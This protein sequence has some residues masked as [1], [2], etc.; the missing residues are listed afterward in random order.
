MFFHYRFTNVLLYYGVSF[1]SIDLG[2]NRYLNFFLIGLVGVPSLFSSLWAVRRFVE[3]DVTV[4]CNF[5]PP[6]KLS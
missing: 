3:N 5:N 1:G 2:G 6:M 4:T